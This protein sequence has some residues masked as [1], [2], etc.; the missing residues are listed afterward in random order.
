VN[1]PGSAARVYA[2]VR[3]RGFTLIEVL[4]ALAIVTFGMAALLASLTSSADTASYLR[5]KSFAEW[6]GLN[7]I[8]ELRVANRRASL[9]KTTGTVE[10]AGRDWQWQQEVLELQV[11]GLRRV[12]VSVRSA[13]GAPRDFSGPW[14]VTVSGVFGDAIAAPSGRAP[15][16]LGEEDPSQRGQGGSGEPREGEPPPGAPAGG[17][18]TK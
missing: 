3:A 9:G 7:R 17:A 5:D 4:V 10:Y 11:E 14:T 16:L 18:P 2:V 1:A 6:I 8:A 15:D 13:D 12:D